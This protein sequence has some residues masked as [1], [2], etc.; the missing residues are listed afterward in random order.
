[1]RKFV[2]V[3]VFV[4]CTLS[5][6]PAWAKSAEPELFIIKF[7][8]DWCGSCQLLGPKIE[9][10]RG[11]AGLDDSAALFIKLDLTDSTTRN[12][13][14]MMASALGL[15]KYF[16]D[17]AGK[18][19]FAILVDPESKEIKGRITKDMS[20]ETIIELIQSSY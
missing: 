14:A 18:T 8:A 17:N 12:Q 20:A 7:H 16:S 19:G 6:L 5:G 11:K 4:L 1:M 13:A 9:K 3:T 2:L 15:G 10:A